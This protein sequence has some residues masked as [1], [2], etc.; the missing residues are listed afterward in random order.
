MP[1]KVSI[2]YQIIVVCSLPISFGFAENFALLNIFDPSNLQ[3]IDLSNNI[4]G[5]IPVE[6]TECTSVQVDES[7][8]I[9]GG[10]DLLGA[11]KTKNWVSAL[12]LKSLF[13]WFTGNFLNDVR[14]FDSATFSWNY[15]L[16]EENS[17]APSPRGSSEAARL[18]DAVY[19]YGGYDQTGNNRPIP[20]K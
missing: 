12:H 17:T 18:G 20:T 6:R 9:F 11:L 16:D 3:W 19:F 10:R 13:A 14:I 8:L 1:L 5:D 2:F 7:V 4:L 15:M